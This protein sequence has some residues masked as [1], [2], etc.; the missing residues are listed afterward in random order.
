MF[1]RAEELSSAHGGRSS[2]GNPSGGD[3]GSHKYD[4]DRPQD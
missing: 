1:A 2:V 4:H 3:A